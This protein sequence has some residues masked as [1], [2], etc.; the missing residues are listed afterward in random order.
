[1][2][3]S[4]ILT[5]ATFFVVLLVGM[6]ACSKTSDQTTSAKKQ[7]ETESISE[8][9]DDS[10]QSN[11]LSTDN[12]MKSDKN[13]DSSSDKASIDNSNSQEEANP[14][15]K[16]NK[17][18]QEEVTTKIVG[19][20]KEFIERLD[21][22]Q[23]GLDALPYKKDSDNGVTNA[24]KSYYGVSYDRYDKALNEIYTLLQSELSP[25]IMIALKN[26]EIN[27]IKQKEDIANEERLKYNGKT[28]EWVAYYISSYKSTK[29]RCYKLVN[30]YMTD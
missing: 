27:W 25:K 12:T 14:P 9:T 16:S 28:F 26:E 3:N 18:I 10:S 13:D 4:K 30:T 11:H 21:N 8:S 1:M 17:N 20:R 6:S 5:L 29:E 7:S 24:M 15:S 22:I 19:R 23:K 2:K